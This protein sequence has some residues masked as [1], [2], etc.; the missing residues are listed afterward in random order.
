MSISEACD[1]LLFGA[2]A[3]VMIYVLV[4]AGAEVYKSV[5]W[6]IRVARSYLK[7]GKQ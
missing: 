7:G 5:A 3:M 4:L 1:W 2:F 6:K